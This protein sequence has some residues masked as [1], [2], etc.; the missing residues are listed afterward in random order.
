MTEHDNC[1]DRKKDNNKFKWITSAHAT[2]HCLTGCVIG[3]V[4]GLLIGV[5]LGFTAS[6]TILLAF[7]LAYV[8]GFTLGI[9][10]VMKREKMSALSAFK[11]IW[12]GEVIS[13]F[14]MEVAMNTVDYSI[15]GVQAPSV[16][17]L[18]F[19]IGITVAIPAGF[20]ATWPV[21]HWLLKKQLKKCH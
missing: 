3:E 11:V 12:L 13:I 6:A 5:S 15:G 7:I 4:L 14:V 16:F 18:I 10:P 19:W 9:I 8:F 17:S 1:C 21:N 2:F 20:L